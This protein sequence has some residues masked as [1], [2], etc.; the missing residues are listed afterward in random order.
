MLRVVPIQGF[1]VAENGGR[2][3]KRYAVLLEVARGFAGIP[4]EHIS[5]YT[6]IAE[7]WEA[8]LWA[9]AGAGRIKK[10][11]DMSCLLRRIEEGFL[12]AQADAPEEWSGRKCVGLLRSK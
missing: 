10:G 3:F 8:V 1:R 7:I 9:W 11:H 2:L 6:L 12:S 5:V 4:R